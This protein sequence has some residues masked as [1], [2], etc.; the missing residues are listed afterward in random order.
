M[1]SAGDL[2]VASARHGAATVGPHACHLCPVM[3]LG[4][5]VL[6]TN[7]ESSRDTA[8]V[9]GPPAGALGYGYATGSTWSLVAAGA[10]ALLHE[11]IH[12]ILMA[13]A[14]KAG[15]SLGDACADRIRRWGRRK[16]RGPRP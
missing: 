13:V 1:S 12:K 8:R 7:F 15:P 6:G 14:E 3:R 2:L 16:P 10:Y 4:T 5:A 9:Y 11:P